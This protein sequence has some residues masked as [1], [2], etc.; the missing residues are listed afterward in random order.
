MN[1]QK[2]MFSRYWM[3]EFKW[4]RF[5]SDERTNT[6]R[7]HGVSSHCR[8][9]LSMGLREKFHVKKISR[10]SITV[11]DWYGPQVTMHVLWILTKLVIKNYWKKGKLITKKPLEQMAQK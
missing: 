11:A 9:R 10:K 2:V 3:N 8:L 7:E 1:F 6:I 4:Q 5:N